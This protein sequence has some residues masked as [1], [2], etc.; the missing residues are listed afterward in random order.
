VTF[1]RLS[2]L[3][4]NL[5]RAISKALVPSYRFQWPQMVWWQ[6]EEFNA[7]LKRFGEHDGMNSHRRWMVLQLARLVASVPGDTAECGVYA[8]SSSYL[9]CT[10]TQIEMRRTHF[11]FDSFEGLSQPSTVDGTCWQRGDLRC[12]VEAVRSKLN[13]NISIHPGWIP[14]RFDDVRDRRFAFVHIDV[15]LYQPTRDSI[16]FFYPRTTTGGIIVCDDYGFMTCPGATKAVDDFLS[17]KPEKMIIL[18][19]G[20]G[21]LIKDVATELTPR[22]I[23]S[24]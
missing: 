2:D 18:P 4:F 11:L 7:Y 21:F 23:F 13:G 3:R 1:L 12:S 24:D 6:D 9:I 20:G 5:L 19:C 10:A 14:H 17:D 22:T 8:G 16:E 15:D